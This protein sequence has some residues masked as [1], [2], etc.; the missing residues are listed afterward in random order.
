M[1]WSME[2][3]EVTDVDRQR[4]VASVQRTERELWPP[5]RSGWLRS[6]LHRLAGWLFPAPDPLARFAPDGGP[7]EFHGP[8]PWEE[9]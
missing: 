9:T 4:A 5:P 3:H 1:T 7:G 2:G 8:Y 6:V